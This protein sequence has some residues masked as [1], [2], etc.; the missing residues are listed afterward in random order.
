MQIETHKGITYFRDW[1]AARLEANANGM[2]L[3]RLVYYLRGWAIQRERSGP[4]WNADAK[5]WDSADASD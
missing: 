4:Y 3:A 1:G 2:P 5:A